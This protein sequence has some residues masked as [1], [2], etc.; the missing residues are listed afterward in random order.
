[1]LDR[2]PKCGH[3]PLPAEQAFPAACPA[4]GVILARAGERA[5]ARPLRPDPMPDPDAAPRLRDLPLHVP[6]RVDPIA[7]WL[8]AALLAALA[9]WGWWLVRADISDGE[10]GRSVIHLPLLV[11]H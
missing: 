9:A 4:C 2:C 7:W 3:R 1:M 10:I 5:P 6:D 11:F 8:R